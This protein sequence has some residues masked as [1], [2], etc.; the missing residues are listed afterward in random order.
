MADGGVER[1]V[2]CYAPSRGSC[3]RQSLALPFV[4]LSPAAC[5]PSEPHAAGLPLPGR[6]PLHARCTCWHTVGSRSS[7]DERARATAVIARS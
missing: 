5:S 2:F 7:L 3:Q 1:A 4:P 6:P